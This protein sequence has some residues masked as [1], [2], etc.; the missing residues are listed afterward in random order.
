[1]NF[2]FLAPP[3]VWVVAVIFSFAVNVAILGL[4]DVLIEETRPAVFAQAPLRIKLTPSALPAEAP[5][6]DDDVVLT[7]GAPSAE[8]SLAE[9]A[10]AGEITQPAEVA[11]ASPAMLLDSVS[12]ASD[13][14]DTAG[15]PKAPSNPNGH[16]QNIDL[17]LPPLLENLELD[18][19]PVLKLW[20]NQAPA[21]AVG[22][23]ASSK[24]SSQKAGFIGHPANPALLSVG[25][26]CFSV[27][28]QSEGV[29]WWSLPS[30]CSGA[31][32]DA[33]QMLKNI[34]ADMAKYRASKTELP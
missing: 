26:K 1:M 11:P 8:E 18:S 16:R 30:R 7:T 5:A 10:V 17:N 3:Y 2:A 27:Q 9:R 6:L 13:I 31:R 23:G 28:S 33:S 25:D 14:V 19:A 20:D 15:R 34:E 32:S 29:T 24:Y 21:N 22:A 4:M 12:E